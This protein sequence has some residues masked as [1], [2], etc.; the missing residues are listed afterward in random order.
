MKPPLRFPAS[1]AGFTLTELLV[2]VIL[3]AILGSLVSAPMARI[4]DAVKM[5]TQAGDFLLAL[6]L[7]RSEALKRNVRVTMCKSSSGTSCSQEGD[8]EQGW[9]IFEDTDHDA[10]P[11]PGEAVIQRAGALSGDWRLVGNNTVAS[12]VSYTSTGRT[13]TITGAFQ[14]GSITL[15]RSNTGVSMRQIVINNNGRIRITAGSDAGCA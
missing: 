14:A 3:L 11:D 15:C 5:R 10:Q 6:R 13:R 2:V 7:A 12:Y 4:S 9:I 1:T 8:W